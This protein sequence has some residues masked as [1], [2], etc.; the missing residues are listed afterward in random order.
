MIVCKAAG[1]DHVLNYK[2]D[3]NWPEKVKEITRN[4]PGRRWEGADIILDP[5]GLMIP[6]TKCALEPPYHLP[7]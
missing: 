2:T 5:T 1:A 7:R 4:I 3:P 6:S